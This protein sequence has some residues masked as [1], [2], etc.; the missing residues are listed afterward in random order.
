MA[1]KN[2][3]SEQESLR[4]QVDYNVTGKA[5]N[6]TFSAIIISAVGYFGIY[7]GHDS[8]EVSG[9]NKQ[10]V[11]EN[12]RNIRKLQKDVKLIKSNQAMLNAMISRK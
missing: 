6:Y 10:Y 7:D 3:V 8:K 2:D 4:V 5:L 11:V 12:T 9:S 1:D